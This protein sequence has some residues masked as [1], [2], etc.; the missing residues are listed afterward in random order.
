M[1]IVPSP[2]PTKKWR[3][4]FKDGTHTD[5]GDPKYLDYTEHHDPD[6]RQRYRTRHHKDLETDD[7]KK[8]GYLSYYILWGNS[9]SISKNLLE[10]KKRFGN[11]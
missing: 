2:L 3:A 8:A 10:Y 7:P 6:R 4:E 11:L 5:F 1:H 9:T